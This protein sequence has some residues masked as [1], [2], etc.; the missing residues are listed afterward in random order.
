MNILISGTIKHSE[1]S[2]TDFSQSLNFPKTRFQGSKG[3]ILPWIHDNLKNINYSTVLDGFSGSNIV[4]YYFKSQGKQVFS[5]D[6]MKSSFIGAKALIENS[7]EKVDDLFIKELLE[8]MGY[9]EHLH[10]IE[11]NYDGVYFT[12]EENRWLDG[13]IAKISQIESEYLQSICYWA[14]FQACIIKRPYNLF[15]R[16]NLY[17]RTN[18]VKRSFGNKTTWDRSFSYYLKKFVVEARN[19]IFDNQQ[20]NLALNCDIS[21]IRQYIDVNFDLVYFDPPYMKYGIQTSGNDYQ[22]YYHFLEGILDYENWPSR[23][24]LK[25]K[26]KPYSTQKSD[27]LDPKLIMKNFENIIS[28]FQ[29][30]DIVI[31]YN[32]DGYPSPKEIMSV[33]SAYKSKV[34]IKSIPIK[35]VLNKKEQNKQEILFV[36][37]D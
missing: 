30:S 6:I 19:A 34:E 12:T 27:W 37:T 3:R 8:P 1:V 14:L 5:N 26:H 32:T 31:S 25:L 16:R 29:S 2:I 10:Y 35:Y 20:Q 18:N 9:N 17:M 11:D 15:H 24:N 33:L 4:S 13:F 21:D 7:S 28:M 36:A 22:N 23:L